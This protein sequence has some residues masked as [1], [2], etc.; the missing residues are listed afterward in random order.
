MTS[1]PERRRGDIAHVRLVELLAYDKE[2]GIFRWRTD[3]RGGI[4]SG[5]IAG[6]VHSGGSYLKIGIDGSRYYAHRLAWLYV[7]GEMPSMWVD[8]KDGNT[9]NNAFSNLRHASPSENIANSKTSHDNRC[10][11]KGVTF[12]AKNHRYRAQIQF[13]GQRIVIGSFRSA[14][15]AHAAYMVAAKRYFGDFAFNGVREEARP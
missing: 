8:H 15:A 1:A 13:R 5:D 12:D 7:T 2:T 3:R 6:C 11:L 9:L 10:G 14:K 4:H